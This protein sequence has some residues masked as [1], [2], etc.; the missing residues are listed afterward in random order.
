MAEK[1]DWK[2]LTPKLNPS[3]QHCL[4]RFLMGILIFERLTARH[5]YKSLDIKGLTGKNHPPPPRQGG[6]IFLF[7]V[8]IPDLGPVPSRIQ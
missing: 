4:P 5:L 7:V 1:L 2:G 6:N 8:F 3:A